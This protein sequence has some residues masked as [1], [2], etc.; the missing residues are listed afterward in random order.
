MD[1]NFDRYVIKFA[2]HE[3][4]KLVEWDKL[5]FDER[6]ELHRVDIRIGGEWNLFWSFRSFRF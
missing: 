3:S 4:L 6:V 2:P 1:Q 5:T